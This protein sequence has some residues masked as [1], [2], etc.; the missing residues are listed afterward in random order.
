M[1]ALAISNLTN[2]N[3]QVLFPVMIRT[4]HFSNSYSVG[5]NRR[6]D[7]PHGSGQTK[8]FVAWASSRRPGWPITHLP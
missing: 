6:I 2:D 8:L 4:I 5:L 3:Q 1:I 7:D